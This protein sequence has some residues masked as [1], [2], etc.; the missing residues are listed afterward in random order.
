MP[1]TRRSSPQTR[2]T[3]SASCRPSTSSR[4][5]RATRAGR[6]RGRTEP[7]AVRRSAPG[8][9]GSGPWPHQRDGGAVDFEPARGEGHPVLGAVAVAH[10]HPVGEALEHLAAGRCAT[11][12]DDQPGGR[13]DLGVGAPRALRPVEVDRL[14]EDATARA[15]SRSHHPESTSAPDPRIGQTLARAGGRSA[16]GDSVAWRVVILLDAKGL[17]AS[18]PGRP[19]FADL[20]LTLSDGDRLAVVGLNGCGKSTL[21]RQL[22]GTD[23]PEAGVIRRGRGTRV[24]MLDQTAGAV[25]GCR[26]IR[27]R[28][29]RDRRGGRRVGRR[30]DPRTARSRA[31]G[32]SADAASSRVARPSGSR[33]PGRWSRSAR[34]VTATSRWC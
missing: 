6:R 14:P 33:W 22:A 26:S 4:L 5:A 17:A 24:V 34:S 3:S 29:N 1:S 28:A 8:A 11:L 30:A 23:E 31:D 19:L 18:R 32:R 15:P 16:V 12:L 2:S 27:R 21:L 10:E 25:E 7:E 13:F 20:S 9:A